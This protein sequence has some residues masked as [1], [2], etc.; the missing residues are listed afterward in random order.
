MVAGTA[1]IKA[2]SFPLPA[3]TPQ[4]HAFIHPGGI[5][6]LQPAFYTKAQSLF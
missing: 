6:A 5:K 1:E 4:C 2:N 3:R